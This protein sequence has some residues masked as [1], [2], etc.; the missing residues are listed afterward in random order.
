M[1]E[2]A[3][4]PQNLPSSPGGPSLGPKSITRNVAKLTQT[5]FGTMLLSLAMRMYL[6]RLLGVD[7]LGRFYFAEAFP[8][9]FFTFL[10][11]G[12]ESYIRRTVPGRREHLVEAFW[13]I[14]VFQAVG[15]LVIAAILYGAYRGGGRDETLTFAI[16][17]MGVY[18][19]AAT[20]HRNVIK[21][22]FIAL[23]YVDLT[24][25]VDI[26]TKVAYVG[27]VCAAAFYTKNL[28]LMAGAAALSEV[29]GLVWLLRAARREGF[30]VVRFDATLLRRILVSSAPFMAAMI[31]S[32]AYSNVDAAMVGG[33]AGDTELGYY[34]AA[35]RLKGVFLLFLTIITN[36]LVPHMSETYFHAREKY[37]TLINGFVRVTALGSL[38]LGAGLIVFADIATALLYGDAFASSARIVA[39]LSP[40]VPLTYVSI[41]I[42][43]HLTVVTSGKQIAIIQAVSIA[44]DACLNYVLIKHGLANWGP[45]GA[46]LGAALST[47]LSQLLATTAMIFVSSHG[48]SPFHRGTVFR[49][50]ALCTLPLIALF[51]KYDAIS[52][53]PLALRIS[54]YVILVPSFTLVTGLM[55]RADFAKATAYVRLRLRK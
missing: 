46:G 37:A 1:F 17:L 22:A 16:M 8:A 25:R 47:V 2:I 35:T 50:T 27:G 32:D 18:C 40:T 53:A 42:Y 44:M 36:G 23:H 33:I 3:D 26:M 21:Q 12:I 24:S 52:A 55:T 39:V 28:A 41:L 15:A 31:F 51:A 14:L 9:L 45:G 54:A 38:V 49:L 34:G 11:F 48:A 5:L 19:A 10:N 20:I 13:S 30:L 4:V 43:S 7:L 29:L 6:P